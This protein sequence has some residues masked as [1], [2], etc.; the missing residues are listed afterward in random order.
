MKRIDVLKVVL[1]LVALAIW[2]WGVRTNDNAYMLVGVVFVIAAFLL[3]FLP[4][5][6]K[7]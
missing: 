3:R 6:P 5:P 1:V 4:K 2:A 7:S